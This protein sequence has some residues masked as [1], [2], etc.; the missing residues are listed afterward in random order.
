MF[1]T[2]LLAM[3]TTLTADTAEVVIAPDAPPAVRFAAQEMTNFLSQVLGGVIPAVSSPTPGRTPILLGE[4]VWTDK[5]TNIS[6]IP[7][8]GFAL[9]V[10]D[11]RVCIA[12]RDDPSVDPA[13]R[14]AH[15]SWGAHKFEHGTLNGTYAF[16]ERCAGVRFYFAGE[17]G[18]CVS[19][20]DAIRVPYGTVVK[21]PDMAD[22]R[23]GLYSDG[24]WYEGERPVRTCHPMKALNIFRLRT[25]TTSHGACHGLNGFMYVERFGKTHPEYFAL[26]ARGER[27]IEGNGWQRGHLCL[28]SGI[29]EEIYR[30]CLSFL[31]GEPPSVRGV[32][33]MSKWNVG[34]WN[35]NVDGNGIDLMPQDG[36][37]ACCCGKCQAAA[38]KDGRD[39]AMSELVWG[40]MAEISERLGRD[41]Y[42]PTIRMMSYADYT[43][44]PDCPLPTNLEVQVARTGPWG[45]AIPGMTDSDV[46]FFAKWEKRLGAKPYVW[47]YPNRDGC[48]GLNLEGVPAWA[49]ETWGRYYQTV[50]P[51]L[52]GLYAE[53]ETDRCID[54]L[55]G[56]Y[57]LSRIG[58]NRR[59][60]IAAVM[61]EFYDRMFGA[62]SASMRK[63]LEFVERKF[64]R[65]VA[66][67]LRMTEIGPAA[68]PPSDYRLWREIYSAAEM[69]RLRVWFDEAA[70]SVPKGS[71]EARRIALFRRWMYDPPKA[72]GEAYRAETDAAAGLV[73]DRASK[74]ANLF[75]AGPWK[76][77]EGAFD[78]TVRF[79]GERS[80]RLVA[81]KGRET[82][83]AYS[84]GLGLK[85]STRYRFSYFVKTENLEPTGR[86][87]GVGPILLTSGKDRAGK[88]PSW[89]F[90]KTMNFLSGTVPWIRQSFEFETDA[91]F[92]TETCSAGMCLRI[93]HGVG[94][95]WFDG[96]RLEEIGPVRD[97][98]KK[99]TM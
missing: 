84:C 39:S 12:G 95:A 73:R 43:D 30:D 72:R 26:D 34:K 90:P 24:A 7:R 38:R 79:C 31:K 69:E 2:T 37:A 98:E 9:H 65:E 8:D 80:V 93:R 33:P 78:D 16:L 96:M 77:G 40:L 45:H 81:T 27:M 21:A 44:V 42:A 62:A 83:H 76:P 41:G 50:A 25:S 51:H 99:G 49:P 58:W 88:S 55:M 14:I 15:P 48:N 19:R 4:G 89:T 3:V 57:L 56:Y 5:S 66:G 85:P 35:Y 59:T 64:T 52:N 18:T 29:R 23:W 71:L 91:N 67:S 60:D 46:A 10:S 11:G 97:C 87:G 6:A 75:D 70:A 32:P 74:A 13:D 94:T 82:V 1:L 17:L 54:N 28:S 92:D 68:S 22:R 36:G 86:S 53:S 47:T 63:A 20:K 61:D